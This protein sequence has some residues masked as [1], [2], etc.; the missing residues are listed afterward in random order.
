[1]RSAASL[2][3]RISRAR[4]SR[5]GALILPSC[6]EDP[7]QI[8]RRRRNSPREPPQ[9]PDMSIL[10]YLFGGD[11]KRFERA[12]AAEEARAEETVR[13]VSAALQPLEAALGA[14]RGD[15]GKIDLDFLLRE[16]SFFN[17]LLERMRTELASSPFRAPR[18][19]A[20]RLPCWR[21]PRSG[22][23]RPRR[24]SPGCPRRLRLRQ[25]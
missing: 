3:G 1:M 12:A 2:R 14:L 19:C 20:S 13:T 16:W 25:S 6:D 7:Q 5:R 10:S 4:G 15:V 8:V 11:E 9:F 22:R 17:A 21:R 18:C 23:P 24:G